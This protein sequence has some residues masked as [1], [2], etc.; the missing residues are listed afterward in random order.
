MTL[1]LLSLSGALAQ[2]PQGCFSYARGVPRPNVPDTLASTTRP[3]LVHYDANYAPDQAQK[4]AEVL[5][6]MEHAWDVQVDQLGFRA[7]ELP[8]MADGPEY[9]VY[10]IEYYQGTAFVAAD[11]Y[12]DAIVGDGYSSTSSYMVIDARLPMNWIDLYVAH[13]FNHICQWS[14]DFTEWTTTVWEASATNAQVWTLG[15]AD[16]RWDLDVRDFQEAAYFPALLSDSSYTYYGAGL[17]YLYEY[18]AAIWVRMLDEQYGHNDGAKGVELWDA[19][20]N[21]GFGQEPDVLDA[22]AEVADEPLGEV[23]NQLALVRFLTGDDWDDRGL[24]DAATW[25]ANEAVSAQSFDASDLPLSAE[26]LTPQPLVTGQS[27]VDIDLSAGLSPAPKGEVPYLRVSVASAQAHDAAIIAMWWDDAGQV[28]DVRTWGTDPTLELPSEGLTRLAIGVTN[29]GPMG[30]DGDDQGHIS[31]ILS[32]SVEEFSEPMVD[33]SDTGT[34]DTGTTD[35]GLTPTGLT[36]TG[37]TGAT[38][39]T[40]TPAGTTPTTN[41]TPSTPPTDG[42]SSYLTTPPS[43]DADDGKGCGCSSGSSS[44]P[45]ALLWV[46]AVALRRRR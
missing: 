9:D 26:P 44:A 32:V 22:V 37:T 1:L 25:V 43:D 5:E 24:A 36:P 34:T 8:D 16:G 45:F 28:G 13:E 10:L 6:A 18:G 15:A 42:T 4:A 20:A 40:G 30:F 35:T 33:T 17:G 7:P 12:A 19:M 23:L 39:D 21:E 31:G 29:L 27:F 46:V 11:N 2:S 41:T 3:I 38:G 14:T